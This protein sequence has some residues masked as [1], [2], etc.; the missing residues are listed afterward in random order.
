MGYWFTN[1]SKLFNDKHVSFLICI[2]LL[3][4]NQNKHYKTNNILKQKRF[5]D[6]IDNNKLSLR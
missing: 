3:N 5:K 4:K 6:S 2:V 1:I